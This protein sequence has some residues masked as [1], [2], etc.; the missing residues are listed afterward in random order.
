MDGDL[1][2][3]SLYTYWKRACPPP[4]MMIFDAPTRESC[5]VTRARTETP[6]QALALWNDEQ[7]REAA[8]V[9]AA[10]TLAESGDTAPAW[11]TCSGAC[12]AAR[13]TARSSNSCSDTWRRPSSATARSRCRTGGWLEGGVTPIPGA[14]DRAQLAA[15]T[16]I[17]HGL[18]NHHSSLTNG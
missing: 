2:R 14:L 15:W 6:L 5:V 8:R 17:A 12:A 3:R 13:P 11:C 16:L 10:R 18:L 7:F 4:T 1:H 9:L